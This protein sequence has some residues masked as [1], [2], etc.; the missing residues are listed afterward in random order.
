MLVGEH[1]GDELCGAACPDDCL[2]IRREPA[3]LDNKHLAAQ[4]EAVVGQDAQQLP[5]AD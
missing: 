4:R 3:H 2:V 1:A 5:L